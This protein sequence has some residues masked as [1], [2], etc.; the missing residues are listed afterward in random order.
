[1]NLDLLITGGAERSGHSKNSHHYRGEA[2]D[3]AGPRFNP[4]KDDDVKSCA[5]ECGFGAGL[6]ED[7]PG[8]RKDHR[9]LQRYSWQWLPPLPKPK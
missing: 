3:I 7:Y 9:H 4:V 8:D 1:M 2:F 6:Y 5:S